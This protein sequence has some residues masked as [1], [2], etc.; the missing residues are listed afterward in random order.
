MS[1]VVSKRQESEVQFL[2]N[3]RKLEVY[4]FQRT[5]RMPN[6]YNHFKTI[7]EKFAINCYNYCKLG[8]SIRLK[9]EE[10]LEKRDIYF[11]K[12]LRELYQYICQID[13]LTELKLTDRIKEE[14]M[15][16]WLELIYDEI[17]QIKKIQQSDIKRIK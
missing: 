10:S 14:T 17:E 5:I 7:L 4:T 13:I 16:R 2:E 6:R 9:D 1:V 15:A 11:E 3:A 12:A 8:N